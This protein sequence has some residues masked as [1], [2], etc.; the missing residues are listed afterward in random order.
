MKISKATI[1]SIATLFIGVTSALP[2]SADTSREG[3]W[4]QYFQQSHAESG[5]EMPHAYLDN[6]EM[7]RLSKNDL[8]R[9]SGSHD[10]TDTKR[11]K[12]QFTD[13]NYQA[14]VSEKYVQVRFFYQF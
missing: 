4:L 1:A 9:L 12:L 5:S 8:K 11:S 14:D 13:L 7:I 2:C 6:D 10:E 3:E